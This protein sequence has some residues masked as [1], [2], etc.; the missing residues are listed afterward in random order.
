MSMQLSGAWAEVVSDTISPATYRRL[1]KELP[2]IDL[3]RLQSDN[4]V[5][6]RADGR[7]VQGAHSQRV[8]I[9]GPA[10]CALHRSASLDET[11]RRIVGF[12]V[13]PTGAYVL[14]YMPGDYIG[15]HNDVDDCSV[16]VLSALTKEVPPLEVYPSLRDVPA[17]ELRGIATSDDL[18][19]GEDLPIIPRGITVLRGSQ[20]PHRRVAASSEFKIVAMCFSR[21]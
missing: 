19:K 17:Q 4:Q 14:G 18:E 10:L 3:M 16:T 11:V 1:V 20:L 7:G 13:K 8:A 5:T 2:R 15:L 6:I 21:R 9:A 12:D